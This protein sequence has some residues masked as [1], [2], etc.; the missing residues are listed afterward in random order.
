MNCSVSC[1][2][3]RDAQFHPLKFL[4]AIAEGLPIHEHTKVL[5]LKPGG[6]K[7]HRGPVRAKHTKNYRL[8]SGIT[9]DTGNSVGVLSVT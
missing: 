8:G 6:A 3:Q 2:S 5:E 7:N 4:F 1:F 9:K